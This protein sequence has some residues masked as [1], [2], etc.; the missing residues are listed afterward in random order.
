[1]IKRASLALTTV[2]AFVFVL[3]SSS[4]IVASE[5]AW[6]LL[7]EI[8]IEE[9]ITETDYRAKKVFPAKLR[10]RAEDFEIEGHIVPFKASVAVREFILVDESLECPFCS[11]GGYGPVLEVVLQRPQ[12]NLPFEQRVS[13]RGRLEL[14]EDTG[15]Y[16]AFR[17]VDATIMAVFDG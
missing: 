16:Q 5:E 14:I 8:E 7:A 2:L 6:S 17:L 15:T 11:G 9:E 10:A 1:M 4:S 13:V 12:S 3:F